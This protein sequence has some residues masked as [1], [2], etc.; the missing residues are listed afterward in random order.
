MIWV[1]RTKRQYIHV[2][3]LMLDVT[4]L[5][6]YIC[7]VSLIGQE[8]LVKP[9][10][11]TTPVNADT[12]FSSWPIFWS[13][14]EEACEW[15]ALLYFVSGFVEYGSHLKR[16]T[17]YLYTVWK[18]NYFSV[19]PI[20]RVINFGDSRNAKYAIFEFRFLWILALNEGCDI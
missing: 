3:D 1:V 2:Q 15:P 16:R 4:Y 5:K 20:L 19:T 6:I 13:K 11:L 8:R 10:L 7:T 9:G 17:S 12:R 18:F 14:I